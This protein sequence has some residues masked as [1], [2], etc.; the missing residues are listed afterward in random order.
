MPDMPNVRSNSAF[1]L[2][3]PPAS[4]SLL[5]LADELLETPHFARWIFVRTT[6]GV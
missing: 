5:A 2:Q 6:H 3:A 1:V 4:Y